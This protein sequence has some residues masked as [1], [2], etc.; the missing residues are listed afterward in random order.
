MGQG[1]RRHRTQ[2]HRLQENLLAEEFTCVRQTHENDCGV[3]ALAT[4]AAHHGIHVS[5]KNLIS[6][7]DLDRDGTDFLTLAG[8]GASLNL[9]A[10]GVCAGYEGIQDCPLPAIAHLRGLFGGRHFVVIHRWA[11]AHVV[12]ADPANGLRRLTRKTFCRDWTG[13][14]LLLSPQFGRI[15]SMTSN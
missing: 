11:S 1:S 10:Q 13:Y 7:V 3:A 8:L 6:G 15:S 14:L 2:V 5:Y 4:V 12:I 9:R